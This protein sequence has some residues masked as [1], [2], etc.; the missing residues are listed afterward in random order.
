MVNLIFV[1]DYAKEQFDHPLGLMDQS[2]VLGIMGV[3]LVVQETNCPKLSAIGAL[4][5]HAHIG[6]H[7]QFDRSGIV[8]PLRILERIW[9]E[10][11]P[12]VLQSTLTIPSRIRVMCRVRCRI[13]IA[14]RFT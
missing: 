8:F 10:I 7:V 1:E 6:D 4:N 14:F 2:D 13:R 12:L 3:L 9:N 5:G 11:K